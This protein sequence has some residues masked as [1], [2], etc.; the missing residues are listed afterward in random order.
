MLT[1]FHL[2]MEVKYQVTTRAE[3]VASLQNEGYQIIMLD[4][5]VPNWKPKE[6][7]LH[8]DHHKER[9]EP[10]QI[11]EMPSP[12]TLIDKVC[13][14]T[15][16]VDADA[17]VAA[18][19]AQLDPATF[20]AN[21]YRKL[22]AIA[23]DCDHLGV[24]ENL[25]DHADFAAQCVAAMK[26]EGFGLVKELRLNPDRKTWTVEDKE[27]YTSTA[28]ER[29][30]IS[31][32]EAVANKKSFPG[33]N[34]EA[35]E[36]WTELN[37]HVQEILDKK[38]ISFCKDCAI[39]DA[40]YFAGVYVDPRAWIK[41]LK[42]IHDADSLYPMTLTARKVIVGNQYKGMSYT[43]GSIPLH[44]DLYA[45]DYTKGTFEALSK[46][47]KAINPDAEGWGGRAT[48]GG[49]GWNTPSDLTP[50]GVIEIVVDTGIE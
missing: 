13:F 22:S 47:E 28:F 1:Y 44:K 17:C 14:V 4:G 45:L 2:K 21:T 34:G 27:K 8:Y 29:G 15:T 33:E 49:S 37:I 32:L 12:L 16:Q 6:I 35:S 42:T 11:Y 41:A 19:Y 18:C 25:S 39:F 24:P 48:V 5:T 38:L 30:T 46:A 10:I 9:G 31:L 40:T 20:S 23:F 7:D 50:R 3:I 43:L 26:Q 36:Y